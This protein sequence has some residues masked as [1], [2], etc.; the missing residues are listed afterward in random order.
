MNRATSKAS[1]LSTKECGSEVNQSGR[2]LAII[3]D[4]HNASLQEIMREYRARHGN[5]E[6]SSVSARVNKM[7]K[8]EEIVEC[9][10]RKC[11]I[12]LRTINPLKIKGA[13]NHNMYRNI[14]YSQLNSIP[15]K[16]VWH[17]KIVQSCQEC[18]RNISKYALVEI[19]TQ[20][21]YLQ[22]LNDE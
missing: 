16:A 8:S 13:C 3:H 19:K 15:K 5:I 22:G 17:G 2:I 21:E 7:K 20:S 4:I 1:F 6:L 9:A 12:S 14:H 10:P 11:S 18:G